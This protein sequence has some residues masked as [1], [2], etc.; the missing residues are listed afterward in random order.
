MTREKSCFIATFIGTTGIA[1]QNTA[2]IV[3]KMD[4]WSD[5]FE[6][7]RCQDDIMAS[8][9][10]GRLGCRKLNERLCHDQREELKQSRL[11]QKLSVA[12]LYQMYGNTFFPKFS[13]NTLWTTQS[14]WRSMQSFSSLPKSNQLFL[15]DSTNG[16]ELT[17][18]NTGLATENILVGK[19]KL[20][21]FRSR[22]YFFHFCHIYLSKN[23]VKAHS[24]T[25]WV[26][27]PELNF[28][29]TLIPI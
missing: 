1:E 11:S 8:N 6:S 14:F 4:Y 7:Q 18:I 29:L 3:S 19:V 12:K 28:G 10:P 16:S 15:N 25:E 20:N 23:K 17:E 2:T 27:K 5:K 13:K 26:R 24:P 21:R 9:F 22:N